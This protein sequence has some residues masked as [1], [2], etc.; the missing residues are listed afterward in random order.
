MLAEHLCAAQPAEAHPA[1]AGGKHVI[2]DAEIVEHLERARLH[3]LRA[4]ADGV[5]RAPLDQPHGDA[6]T[7][8]IAGEGEAGRTRAD[9]EH[10]CR[11]GATPVMPSSSSATT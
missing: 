5:G 1:L 7:R 9:D 11:H 3:A 8:Q 10:G 6:A 2:D 4:R